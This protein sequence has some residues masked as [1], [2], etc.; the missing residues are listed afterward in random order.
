MMV[1]QSLIHGAVVFHVEGHLDSRTSPEFQRAVLPFIEAAPGR[2]AL[3]LAAVNYVSS[4]GLRVILVLAKRARA[5]GSSLVA[6]QPN[7]PVRE[8]FEIAGFTALV[9][10]LASREA[11]ALR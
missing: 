9:P 8:V 6:I 7:N 1:R 2:F 3:D 11:L 5:T 10:I 4:A